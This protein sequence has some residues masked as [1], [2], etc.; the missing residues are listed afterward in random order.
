MDR[1]W[2]GSKN[3]LKTF[4][5]DLN[6]KHNSIKFEYKVS[7]SS[8]LFLGMEVYI[9]SNKLFTNIYRKGTDR[10]NFLHVNSEH[11]MSVKNSIHYSQVLGV[12]CTCSTIETSGFIA[13]NLSKS[14]LR[15][16]TNLKFQINTYKQLK[17]YTEMKA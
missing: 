5:N 12:K 14:L 15:K 7:Q 16:D 6:T 11:P 10:Q 3:Q 1:I 13:Q 2:T 4:L 9:K 17:N 8:M